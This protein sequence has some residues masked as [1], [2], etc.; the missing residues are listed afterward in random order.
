VKRDAERAAKADHNG[1][2]VD[3]GH[4]QWT[5]KEVTSMLQKKTVP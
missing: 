4:S 5:Q 3:K 1:L 2:E